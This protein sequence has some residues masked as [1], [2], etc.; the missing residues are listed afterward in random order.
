MRIGIDMGHATSGA[1][2]AVGILTEHVENRKIG[3]ELIRILKE[4]GHTVVN[5]SCDTASNSDSQLSAI[6][7]KANAQTLDL[8]CSIHLNAGGGH[9]TETYVYPGCDKTIAKRVNDKIV[10]SCGFRNRGVKEANFYVLRNTVAP[11]LL[12][13]VCFVDSQEDAGKINTAAVA[14]AIAEGILNQSVDTTTPPPVTGGGSTGGA[15]AIGDYNG[16][17][18]TTDVLNVRAGRGTEHAV[19][20]KLDA[21]QVVT[22]MYILPDNRDGKGDSALWGSIMLNGKTGYIHLGYA[23]PVSSSATPT[24]PPAPKKEYINL[25]PTATGWNVYPTNV[26]PV[27]GNQCGRLAPSQFGGLSYEILGKPQANVFTIQT[28]SFGRVN[29]YGGP[30][31]S[32]TFTNYAKY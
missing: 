8:F 20:G 31:T 28:S 9:G 4:K 15:F 29:I 18:K 25:P 13:E 23:T 26:A 27:V 32:A 19:I 6:V 14:K 22:V 7:K 5:C 24:P 21:G 2:G 17:V 10:A 12:T 30:D 16:N 3:N 1:V 11:A